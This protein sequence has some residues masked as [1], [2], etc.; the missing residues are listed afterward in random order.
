LKSN[1]TLTHITWRSFLLQTKQMHQD[2]L[3]EAQ[4][5]RELE[6]D[7]AGARQT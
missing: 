6:A 5:Q 1:G 3:K 4:R 2:F 7:G